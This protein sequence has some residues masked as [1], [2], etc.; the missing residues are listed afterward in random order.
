MRTTLS[1]AN[2]GVGAAD[3]STANPVRTDR[4]VNMAIDSANSNFDWMEAAV[5]THAAL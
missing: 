5:G 1:C 2:A 4:R 3:A